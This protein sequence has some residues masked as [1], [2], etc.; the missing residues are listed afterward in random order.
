MVNYGMLCIYFLITVSFSLHCKETRNFSLKKERVCNLINLLDTLNT[1]S[2]FTFSTIIFLHVILS[3]KSK[4]KF[5]F[6]TFLMVSWSQKPNMIS[7][8]E[9]HRHTFLCNR[10]KYWQLY[11]QIFIVHLLFRVR[12]GTVPVLRNH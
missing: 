2:N 4:E 5:H 3:E 6:S 10:Q 12:L 11:P 8:F 1:C 9:M 7:N